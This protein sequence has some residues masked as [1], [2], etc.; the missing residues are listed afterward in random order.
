[1]KK[2]LLLACVFISFATISQAQ[3]TKGSVLLG[4][5]IGLSNGKNTGTYSGKENNIYFNP[6]V[7]IAIKENWIIGI[8]GGFSNYKGDLGLYTPERDGESY[9]GGL[10]ARRYSALGKNF[11]LYGNGSINYNKVDQ[12]ETSSTNNSANYYANFYHSKGVTLSIAPGIAYA[13]NKWFHLEASLSNLLTV[14]Y[15]TSDRMNI[16]QSGGVTSSNFTKS[17][18]FDVGTNFNPTSSL[19]IGFRFVLGK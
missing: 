16:S 11:Y 4:G 5:S 8:S 19:Y 13:I 9:S 2:A 18:N 15:S 7:G 1:M 17:K 12:S 10:F 3:I 14:G 6:T